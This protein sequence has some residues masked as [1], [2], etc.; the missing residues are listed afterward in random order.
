MSTPSP[1]PIRYVTSRASSTPSGFRQFLDRVL[2][3]A[4]II[5]RGTVVELGAGVCWLSAALARRPEVERVI[6][7]EFSRRRLERLAPI[8]IAHLAAPAE[9]IERRLADFHDPGLADS[10]ADL[11][12][13]DAAFHHA[14]DPSGLTRT[15]YRLLRPGGTFLMLREPTLAKLRRRRDH[16]LEGRHGAFEREYTRAEYLSFLRTAGFAE[17]SVRAPGALSTLRGRAILH[18]PLSWLNGV[19]FSEYAYIGRKATSAA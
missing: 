11:V 14:A 10:S 4:G 19:A 8:A 13:T 15:A 16:G 9:K 12:V 18:R 6:A 3:S 2:G 7:V 17:E 1:I 5:P